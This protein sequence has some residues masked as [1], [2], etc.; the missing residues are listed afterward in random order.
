MDSTKFTIYCHIHTESG[1]RYVGLTKRT[2]MWRWNR[3]VYAANKQTRG[4]SHFANAIRLYGKDAF[5]HEVLESCDSLEEANAAEIKWIEHFRTRDPEYGFNLAK[6]GAHTP[7]PI[8]NP[9][10][11]PEYRTK[12]CEASRAKWEDP[13]FR[14]KLE[15]KQ[16]EVH[17][18]PEWKANMSTASKQ[19]FAKPEVRE[20]HSNSLKG[21]P[22]SEETRRKISVI[23]KARHAD[24]EFKKKL[25]DVAKKRWKKPG[26]RERQSAAQHGK[27]LS[28][29]HEDQRCQ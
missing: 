15:A 27:K 8:S 7:H 19:A 1:R 28:A 5:S 21:R 24:P 13:D 26:Y 18:R 6:G 25:S 4:W 12:S 11:R 22:V 14:A 16:K 2:M 3:H 17:S 9:W 20:K 10:D 29:E 23:V